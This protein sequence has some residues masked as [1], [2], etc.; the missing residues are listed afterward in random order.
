MADNKKYYYLKLKDNFFESDELK[1]L[2][3]FS[4]GKNEGYIYSDILLKMYLKS[5]QNEGE[6]LFRGVIPYS[7]EMLATVTNHSVSEVKDAIEKFKSLGLITVLENGTVFMNDIQLFIGKSSTEADRIK[8]YRNKLNNVKKIDDV[9]MYNKRT[10]EIRDKSLEI[11]DKRKDKPSPPKKTTLSDNFDKLWSL[12]PKKERKKDA[13]NA[14]KRVIKKGVTNKQIQDG[15][16][17]YKKY[18][19]VKDTEKKFIAQGGTWFNQERW[20]DEYDLTPDQKKR[21]NKFAGEKDRNSY[22]V[23]F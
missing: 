13:F 17:A 1:M 4:S 15:I 9:Q 5:L 23:P 16:V 20:N 10:P 19:E 8:A 18:I 6:L 14:Y 11:R 7:P 12:Y 21:Y 2:Q 3:S 22:E